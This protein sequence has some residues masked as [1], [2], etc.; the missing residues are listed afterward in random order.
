MREITG[1][2]LRVRPVCVDTMRG[3]QRHLRKT[4]TVFL[5]C[6]HVVEVPFG[7]RPQVGRK[8]TCPECVEEAVA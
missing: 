2:R 6:K 1:K 5:E 4:F 3:P 7:R 8:M